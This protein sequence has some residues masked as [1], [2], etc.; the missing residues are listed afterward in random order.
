VSADFTAR[1]RPLRWARA[2]LSSLN[3][4]LLLWRIHWHHYLAQSHSKTSTTSPPE[5]HRRR[6]ELQLCYLVD[7]GSNRRPRSRTRGRLTP[8]NAV[9]PSPSTKDHRSN[10]GD[11]HLHAPRRDLAG[12]LARS[13]V[14]SLFKSPPLDLDP[15]ALIDHLSEP[16]RFNMMHLIWL[17][18]NAPRSRSVRIDTSEQDSATC[19]SQI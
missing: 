2:P 8:L 16:V 3:L 10:A 11:H 6:A 19:L 15:V 7:T 17:R 9:V 1:F 5:G 12:T 4:L 13:T 14:P 18:S